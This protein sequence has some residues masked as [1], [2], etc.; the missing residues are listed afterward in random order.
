MS[1]PGADASAAAAPAGGPAT[2]KKK[3][4]G[5]KERQRLKAI[6]DGTYVAPVLPQK[7]PPGEARASRTTGDGASLLTKYIKEAWTTTLCWRRAS[8]TRTA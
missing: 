8:S 5:K 4:L 3:K 7:Q 1:V 2:G 6:A